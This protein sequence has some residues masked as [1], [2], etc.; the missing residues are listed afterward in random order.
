LLYWA[1]NTKCDALTFELFA[2]AYALATKEPLSLVTND[3]FINLLRYVLLLMPCTS[4]LYLN[5]QVAT[6]RILMLVPES[7]FNAILSSNICLH[8]QSDV[9]INNDRQFICRRLLFILKM[10]LWRYAVE[11]DRAIHPDRDL[12]PPLDIARKLLQFEP[13]IVRA[14][15]FPPEANAPYESLLHKQQTKAQNTDLMSS[16]TNINTIQD[17]NNVHPVDA[18]PYALRTLLFQL[19]TDINATVKRFAN[20]LLFEICHRDTKE[21]TL[22]CGLGNAVAYLQAQRILNGISYPPS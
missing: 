12:V 15:I 2:V 11:A 10:Q 22:R 21:F 18:P 14:T 17:D 4:T 9:D 19:Q 1:L 5:R 20:E 8:A 13:E 6:L 7:N 16:T 3:S